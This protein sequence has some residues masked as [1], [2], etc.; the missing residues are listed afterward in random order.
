[1]LEMTWPE[2][3][4]LM[5]EKQRI[6]RSDLMDPPKNL[7]GGSSRYP[8]EEDAEQVAWLNNAYYAPLI[9]LA[10][11]A[12]PQE[13]P[14]SFSGTDVHITAYIP[15][16]KAI[17]PH[18]PTAFKKFAE[19]QTITISSARGVCPVRAL[20]EHWIRDYAR[21]TRTFAGTL[22][23]SVLERDVFGSMY[24]MDLK[25]SNAPF[26]SFIDQIPPMT[27]CISAINEFGKQA[28][29]ALYEVT[30]T[31]FGTAF[32]VDDLFVENTY[33]YVAKWVT[34]FM[35]GPASKALS[36]LSSFIRE[37]YTY[38]SATDLNLGI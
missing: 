33:N 23:F 19:V 18:G 37:E 7:V 14:L 13:G 24:Q 16:S 27:I 31:N 20:G 34:P 29:M 5:A 1:M 17:L 32:S 36:A 38:R 3:K 9:R 35:P 28:S 22:I 12:Y 6:G 4:R 25:D 8:S 10:R 21:G 2:I 11:E 26:T 15:P 30:L